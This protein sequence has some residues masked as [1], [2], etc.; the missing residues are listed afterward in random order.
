M[1]SFSQIYLLAFIHNWLTYQPVHPRTPHVNWDH[2]NFKCWPCTQLI[3]GKSLHLFYSC[4][5][6]LESILPVC[7]VSHRLPGSVICMRNWCNDQLE[8]RTGWVPLFSSTR[9][10]PLTRVRSISS[11]PVLFV[12]SNKLQLQI[13][14]V[15]R[16]G[17]LLHTCK[18][19]KLTFSGF[20][21]SSSWPCTPFHVPELGPARLK[22]VLGIVLHQHPVFS[23]SVPWGGL[24]LNHIVSNDSLV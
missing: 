5:P 18:P 6:R 12:D 22:W 16:L 23:W 13:A 9:I 8:A 1:V 19:S 4:I 21:L 3:R 14:S 17:V 7:L 10:I 20:F 15:P 2:F 24:S 11:K